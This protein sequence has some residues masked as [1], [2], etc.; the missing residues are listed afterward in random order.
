MREGLAIMCLSP[1]SC[2][3]AHS[4]GRLGVPRCIVCYDKWG[5][6]G[7]LWHVH[8]DVQAYILLS[9]EESWIHELMLVF[10]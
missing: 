4:H 2:H 5:H 9:G 8:T 3:F 1:N 6:S 10:K 7:C